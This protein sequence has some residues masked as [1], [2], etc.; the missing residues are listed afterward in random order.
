M[1]ELTTAEIKDFYDVVIVGAGPSGCFTARHLSGEYEVLVLDRAEFPRSKPCGGMLVEETRR[2]I[3]KLEPPAFIFTMPR[4]LDLRYV[5]WDNHDVIETKRKF[6]N[7]SRERFDAWMFDLMRQSS[8]DFISETRL[9]D[10]RKEKEGLEIV[11]KGDEK[12]TVKTRFL[13]GADGPTAFVRRKLNPFLGLSQYLAI[14]ERAE[15]ERPDQ[16]ASFILDNSITDF[17]SWIIPKR[18]S[19]IVGSAIEIQNAERKFEMFKKKVREK[20]GIETAKGV[21][22]SLIL[23]PRHESEILLGREDILLVGESA[24]LISPSTGEGISFALRSGLNA[25]AVLNESFENPYPKYCALCKPLI[26]EIREKL[27]KSKMLSSPAL[28][29][30]YLA[31]LVGGGK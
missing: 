1:Q 12:K 16:F 18:S 13:V 24:G 4:E 31:S 5:D 26:E 10:F 8:V 30:K 29:K 27:E 15:V 28:R 3:E 11:V 6:L 21:E 14:Q 7:V 19:T 17:Y 25:A 2:V 20:T 9:L 22:A 23:R